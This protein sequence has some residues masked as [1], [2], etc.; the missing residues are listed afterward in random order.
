MDIDIL[1][2]R[3]EWPE[4]GLPQLQNCVRSQAPALMKWVSL[5][6]KYLVK[7]CQLTLSLSLSIV[8]VGDCARD[9]SGDIHCCHVQL[10]PVA[11]SGCTLFVFCAR[12]STG[13]F[14]VIQFRLH[15]ELEKRYEPNIHS[16]ENS[17]FDQVSGTFIFCTC[18]LGSY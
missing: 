14:Q 9:G 17:G 13:I 2:R 12:P 1:I 3:K 18:T 11:F 7:V 6:Y 8:Y 15:A 10:I 5:Q 4:G 16:A